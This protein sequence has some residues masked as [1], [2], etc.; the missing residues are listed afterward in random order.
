M[1]SVITLFVFVSWVGLYND[2]IHQLG[3]VASNEALQ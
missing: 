3:C 1:G 2:A